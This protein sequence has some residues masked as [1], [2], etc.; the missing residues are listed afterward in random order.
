MKIL[1]LCHSFNSLSQRLFVELLA[2]NHQLY[3]EFDIN[4]ATS[5]EA[6]SLIQPDLIIAPFLKRAIPES[7][8]SGTPCFIV[9]PG[10]VGDRGPSAL[11]WAILR[12]KTKWGV[13][14]LQAN[15]VWDGGPV[16]AFRP[17]T[18]RATRKASLYRTEVT[19]AA[20]AAVLEAIDK[21][22]Q[23]GQP[24]DQADFPADQMGTWQ[25]PVAQQDRAINWAT[26][27]TDTV[28]RK[29]RSGD[30]FPGCKSR[31]MNQDV[32]LFDAMPARDVTAGPGEPAGRCGQAVCIGTTDGAVWIGHMQNKA[33]TRSLKLPSLQVMPV[34]AE[35]P[36]L[37]PETGYQPINIKISN[38]IAYLS[39]DF[40][41]GAMSTRQ[42]QQ[43]MQAYSGLKN[44]PDIHI[45]ILTGGE[46]FWSNGIHLNQ[47]E[48]AES[49]A[50]E[51]WQNI[52]AMNDLCQ[53]IIETTDKM[54]IAW[55]RGNAGAGGVFLALTCDRVLARTGIVLNP[56]YKSMGNL[57]GSEYWTY[58][59]PKRVG[60]ESAGQIMNNRLPV[61]A[62]EAVSL[63]LL[64]GLV[65]DADNLGSYVDQL[66]DQV[67]NCIHTKRKQREKDEKEKPLAEYRAEE[68]AQMQL[69]FYGFDPSYHVARYYFVHKTPKSRTPP[70]IAP[71]RR[72]GFRESLK[73]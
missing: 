60:N 49:P 59:L 18:M 27:S 7:I 17:F 44:N 53:E 33:L 67:N 23:G 65:D 43:V 19:E 24:V 10:P 70:Y 34:L 42:C 63:G 28:L 66:G 30:G 64:D 22:S 8:W 29:I 13:T 57:Y 20:C 4:D 21:F 50:D 47:I 48:Q 31:I 2:Q 9:H 12:Q 40:Y 36:E 41:N 35:L 14:V 3:V 5:L 45:I 54:T 46:D 25:D 52:N 61:S 6:V 1:L 58:L 69:N 26:D 15:E 62:A 71:H 39:F 73:G 56:H 16:W 37:A 38:N 55:L 11:D 72:I 51:S 32:Y 68:L